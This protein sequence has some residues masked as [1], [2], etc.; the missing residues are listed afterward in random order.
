MNLFCDDLIR[1]FFN[2]DNVQIYGSDLKNS[3]I[4]LFH[5]TSFFEKFG[6]LVWGC[7]L[8]NLI[9]GTIIQNVN[10]HTQNGGCLPI[11]D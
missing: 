9:L 11:E 8:Q 6:F 7:K 1:P 2:F 4:T 5:F 3:D 10:M